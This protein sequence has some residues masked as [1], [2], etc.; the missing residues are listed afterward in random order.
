M[1]KEEMYETPEAKV[2]HLALESCICAASQFT[3]DNLIDDLDDD[4]DNGEY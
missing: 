2:V 3:R 4:Y 1:K